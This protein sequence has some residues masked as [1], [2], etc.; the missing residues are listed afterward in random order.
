MKIVD[1]R[2]AFL[3]PVVAIWLCFAATSNLRA[4][5]PYPSANCHSASTAEVNKK[6]WPA[7]TTV[8]VYI[9]PAIT[10]LRRSRIQEAF[11]NW[12]YSGGLNGSQ[13]SY[14][15]VSQ[16]SSANYVVLNQQHPNGNRASTDT[17][18]DDITG[19]TLSANTYVS[20]D[21]TN[22]LAVLEA[23]S[24]EIGHP[25]G[26]AHCGSCATSE[27]IMST[28]GYDDFNDVTGRPDVADSMRQ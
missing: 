23:M 9:D 8:S 15:S 17:I 20:P 18:T 5:T 25:A 2:S 6:G 22:P 24:H 11:N 19:L 1:Q 26:F 10:G 12:T 13:V 28:P 27:S 21:M 3:I 14:E 4:Q 16:P 7:G